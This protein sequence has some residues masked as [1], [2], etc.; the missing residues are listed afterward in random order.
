MIFLRMIHLGMHLYTVIMRSWVQRKQ[1]LVKVQRI[2]FIGQVQVGRNKLNFQRVLVCLTTM[3]GLVVMFLY[4]A[5]MR[6]LV[7]LITIIIVPEMRVQRTYLY[8]VGRRGLNN[9][10]YLQV[11][12]ELKIISGGPLV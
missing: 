8:V 9:K 6:L 11:T 12:L 2:Y 3:T 10:S 4:M 5:T 7:H 1:I